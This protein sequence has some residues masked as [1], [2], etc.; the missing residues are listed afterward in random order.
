MLK[1]T[2][3]VIELSYNLNFLAV[4]FLPLHAAFLKGVVFKITFAQLSLV[5]I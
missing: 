1:V 5:K 3:L 4:F 2:E